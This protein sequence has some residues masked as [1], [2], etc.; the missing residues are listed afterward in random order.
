MSEIEIS[1]KEVYGELKAMQQKE[2]DRQID[3]ALQ[4]RELTRFQRRQ[5]QLELETS[6]RFENGELLAVDDSGFPLTDPHGWNLPVQDHIR[7]TAETLFD[8][9]TAAEPQVK[10][11]QSPDELFAAMRAAATPAERLK[12]TQAFKAK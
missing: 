9:T 2:L 8:L 5:L 10:A 12:L 7:Q 3:A 4:G 11:P 6:T 1:P